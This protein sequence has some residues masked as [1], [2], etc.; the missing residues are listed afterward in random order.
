MKKSKTNESRSPFFQSKTF[1]RLYP[2]VGFYYVII[3]VLLF[4]FPCSSPSKLEPRDCFQLNFSPSSSQQSIVIVT[5]SNT[6]IGFETASSL[7]ERGYIVILACRD[8]HKGKV[9]ANKINSKMKATRGCHLGGE[10]IF[11]VPLDLSSQASVRNF[12]QH[13]SKKYKFLN[14]L[15]NNAGINSCGTSKDRLELCFQTNFLGHFLLTNLLLNHLLSSKN[16]MANGEVEAG[17]VVNLSSVCHHFASPC[18]ERKSGSG[19]MTFDADWWRDTATIHVSKN[20]YKESKLASLIFT[21]ELNRRFNSAGL[22][23]ISCN[24]GS[25]NSDIWRKSPKW[26]VNL[27]KRVYLDTKQGSSTSLVSAIGNLPKEAMYLQPYC[28]P[29]SWKKGETAPTSSFTR[30][31]S[32]PH[33]MFEML[34]PYIGFA[35]TEPRLPDNLD[36]V[37]APALWG[38]SEELVGLRKMQ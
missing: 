21:Y 22:R 2:F 28:Q 29:F 37:C 20:T 36:M 6:G 15:V 26:A 25:V 4:F 5:G 34:G 38:V 3:H 9:A 1:D 27:L 13:F 17:R 33:P 10:A 14:I 8:Q 24:P 23:S 19:S 35:V 11:E 32:T 18:E 31:Y 30:W 12:C 7:V 16:E